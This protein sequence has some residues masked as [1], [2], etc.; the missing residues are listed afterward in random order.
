VCDATSGVRQET[1][2]T[3]WQVGPDVA[4]KGLVLNVNA[5]R[6]VYAGDRASA[7][8]VVGVRYLDLDSTVTLTVGSLPSA[9]YHPGLSPVDVVAGVRGEI[10]LSRAWALPY[11]VDVGAGQ[12]DFTW[13]GFG[14]VSYAFRRVHIAAGY[15]YLYWDFGSDKA[16]EK[17]HFGGP[18]AG[19]KIIF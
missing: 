2:P 16:L 8:V 11:H 15:R 5:A 3:G 14:G 19:V 6:T 1:A 18:V 9:V 13:Q 7:D 12:S 4:L 10:K 17:Q